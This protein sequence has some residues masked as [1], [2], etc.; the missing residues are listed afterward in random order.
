MPITCKVQN[1]SVFYPGKK[2][3]NVF[4]VNFDLQAETITMIIGPN[5]SGKS[6][7]LKA[8]L[9]LLPYEGEVTFYNPKGKQIG[10]KDMHIGYVPQY[11]KFDSTIPITVCEFLQL[12]LSACHQSTQDKKK[13]IRKA[14]QEVLALQLIH[15]QL[16]DLSGGQLQRVILARALLHN[17]KMLILDE[18]ESGIDI[19]GEQYFYDALQKIVKERGVTVLIATHELEIVHKYASQVLCINKKLLCRG[20]PE[21]ALTPKTFSKLYGVNKRLYKHECHS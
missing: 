2:N 21:E 16:G 6:T 20:K 8:L 15:K 13:E 3:P 18:P 19:Q 14:L 7:L 11:F 1:V 17:P 12:T 10:K 5:G 4:K 9:G